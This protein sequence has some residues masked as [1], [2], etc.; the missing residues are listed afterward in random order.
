MSG[1]APRP[2]RGAGT[3]L[4]WDPI[5]DLIGLKER[6]NRLLESVLRKGDFST[7]GLAGWSPPVDLREDRD[8]FILTTEVPAVRRDDLDIRVEG[9]IVTLEGRRALEKGA[10]S[11]LRI[12]RPY[13][14]FSRTFHLPHPVDESRVSARLHLGVLEV[15]LPKSTGARARSIKVQVQ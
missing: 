10:R 8:A 6:M 15:V 1:R 7:G 11:A 4:P 13:G 3:P 9:G 14:S 5:R 2:P 12:E